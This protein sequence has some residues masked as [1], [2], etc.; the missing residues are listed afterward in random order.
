VKTV[1]DKVV[2]HSLNFTGLSNRAKMVG[3]VHPLLPPISAEADPPPSTWLP[4]VIG[5]EP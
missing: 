1:S 2:R 4:I 5:S 3:D